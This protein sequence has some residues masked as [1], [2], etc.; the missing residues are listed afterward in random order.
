M[1]PLCLQ[2]TNLRYRHIKK[3]NISHIVLYHS[4]ETKYK[5]YENLNSLKYWSHSFFLK[6]KVLSNTDKCFK[7]ELI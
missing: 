1:C 6:N 7:P 4:D 3:V 5:Q 2:T